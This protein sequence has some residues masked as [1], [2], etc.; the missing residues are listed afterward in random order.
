VRDATGGVGSVLVLGGGSDLGLATAR[1]LVARGTTTVVLAARAPERLA[2]AAAALRDGGAARVQLVAFDADRTEDHE[3]AL[4]DAWTAAAG[5]VDLVLVAFGVLGPQWPGTDRPDESLAL[6]HTNAL[7]GASAVLRAAARL[8]AQGH[9][10]L[11]V[12]SSV[13]AERPRPANFVYA[14]GK[15][16][17]D[18][19]AR[20]VGEALAGSGVR[21]LV[22]RP[23]FV[24]TKMTEGMQPPPLSATPEQVARAI[25]DALRGDARVVYVPRAM[26]VLALVLRLLPA[27]VV[28]RLPR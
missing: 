27:A 4:D 7:G 9:G 3:R 21:V 22:V 20:G 14:A 2:P 17:V 5:D 11:V 18:F 19:L 15:A 24:A 1:A 8:R 6:L 13:A 26:R 16:T 12:L 23:G 28:R 25:A 10:T